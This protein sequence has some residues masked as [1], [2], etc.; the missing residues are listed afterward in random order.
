MSAGVTG[1]IQSGCTNQRSQRI[2]IAVPF[3]EKCNEASKLPIFLNLR[4]LNIKYQILLESSDI[5]R[6]E[7][8]FALTGGLSPYKFRLDTLTEQCFLDRCVQPYTELN[9]FHDAST[10]CKG[11]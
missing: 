5:G 10:P 11:E 7:R 4:I 1:L 9:K 8:P 6:G 3:A 2:F